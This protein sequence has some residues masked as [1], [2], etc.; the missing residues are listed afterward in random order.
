MVTIDLF[1]LVLRTF[2]RGLGLQIYTCLC[3]LFIRCSKG[4]GDIV[5]Y[6]LAIKRFSPH[7]AGC[8]PGHD[9]LIWMT[10]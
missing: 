3:L 2:P 8:L 9:N 6:D 4:T 10:T 5:I 7:L 1:S